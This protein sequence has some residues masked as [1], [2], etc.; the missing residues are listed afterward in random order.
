[1]AEIH[2]DL[3]GDGDHIRVVSPNKS[4]KI[5][6]RDRNEVAIAQVEFRTGGY[7]G[8]VNVDRMPEALRLTFES[9]EDIVNNQTFSLLDQIEEEIG[10][11][12]FV[13]VF[14]DGCE[15]SIKDLQIF[16]K[17]GTVSFTVAEPAVLGGRS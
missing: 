6:D 7:S 1:M 14:E 11:I 3:E 16:P 17:S 9:Y 15:S 12:P 13:A 8:S 5:V 2:N 10:A 4:V